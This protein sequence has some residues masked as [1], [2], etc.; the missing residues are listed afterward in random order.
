MLLA[1]AEPVGLVLHPR[2][3]AAS[4]NHVCLNSSD[5]TPIALP[6]RSGFGI[7]AASDNTPTSPLR[8]YQHADGESRGA[9]EGTPEF[10]FTDPD[11]LVIQLQD[12][13]YCGG[14][15]V[16]GNV[17]RMGWARGLVSRVGAGLKPKA[18]S[19]KINL[20]PERLQAA[21]LA[22]M[23]ASSRIE[24]S[25]MRATEGGVN[26]SFVQSLSDQRSSISDRAVRLAMTCTG[27]STSVLRRSRAPAADGHR[28]ITTDRR[29]ASCEEIQQVPDERTPPHCHNSD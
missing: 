5:S 21:P 10:Y 13:S 4:I 16:L 18:R 11:G 14:G 29:R 15:G 9:K 28:R 24:R 27:T 22:I 23:N 1:A 2:R 8:W 26:K 7:E 25:C 12:V 6:K 20:Q 19:R 3:R 17:H